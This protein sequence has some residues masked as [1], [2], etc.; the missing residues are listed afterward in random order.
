MKWVRRILKWAGLGLAGLAAA[1]AAYQQIG[2]VR[3][4]GLAPPASEMVTVAGRSVHL[5]CSG[6]G[7]RTY[8]LDAGLGAGTFEWWRMQPLLARTGRVC[9][10]DRAGLGWSAPSASVRDGASAAEELAALVRTAKVPT[11]F[12]YVGHSLG[13]NYAMIYAARHP[14]DV[15]ALVLVEPGMPKDLLEDFPGSR[16]EA[17]AATDCGAG[18]YAA[19]AAAYLGVARLAAR[20]LTPGAKNLAGRARDEYRAGLARPST[21]MTMVQELS[22]VPRTA[23]EDL[24]V[25]SFGATPV[26][27]F[28]SSKPRDPEGKETVGDVAKWRVEQLAWLASLAAKSSRGEGPVVVPDSSHAS[29]VM[30]EQQAEFMART[31]DGFLSKK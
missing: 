30:G 3:D 10:F 17:M 29:M 22:A 26:L 12:V 15:S 8:V 11:P 9:A 14:G 23:Y 19:G 18:C 7:T 1:G 6:R 31:I 24:D 20:I 28:A 2:A 21:V 27:V 5:E 25:R 13:A 16:A 4:A